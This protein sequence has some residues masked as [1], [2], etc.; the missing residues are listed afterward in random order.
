MPENL[1]RNEVFHDRGDY[2][3]QA[4]AD[5]HH[6]PADHSPLEAGYIFADRSRCN[7][8]FLQFG[9]GP[10][11][12]R[13]LRALADHPLQMTVAA[14][15][16]RKIHDWLGGIGEQDDGIDRASRMGLHVYRA[17]M[18]RAWGARNQRLEISAEDADAA[19]Q[20]GEYQIRQREY[21]AP[22]LGDDAKSRALNVVRQTIRNAGRITLRDLRRKVSSDHLHSNFDFFR[23]TSYLKRLKLVRRSDVAPA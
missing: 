17:A 2:Q 7:R 14:E 4:R 3:G 19:V 16:K 12:F 8:F 23:F 10:Y 13:Q 6:A 11:M 15:A 18:A 20:L 1:W 5:H 22:V 9:G 21:Y